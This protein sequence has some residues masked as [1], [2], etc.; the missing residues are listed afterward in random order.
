MTIL[1]ERI[2]DA[3]GAVFEPFQIKR[4]AKAEAEAA[5]IKAAG[6]IEVSDLQRRAVRRLVHQE[7]RRQR[8]IEQ[9]TS[10]ALPDVA[11]DASPERIESDWLDHFFD[12]SRRVSD[13]EMQTIWGRL[14]AGEAN[15][16]GAFSRRTIELVSTLD[17]NDVRLFTSLCGFAWSIGNIAPLIYDTQADIYNKAGIRFDSLTH[18]DS[19]GLLR[20]EALSGF[21]RQRLPKTLTVLY[22]GRPVHIEYPGDSDN[23]LDIGC[24]VLT[25]AGQELAPIAGSQP[26]DGFVDY[27][28][29]H[30]ERKGYKAYLTA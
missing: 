9:V 15:K 1:I 25:A 20:V 4:V 21:S 27:V 17:K 24:V 7:A 8:N 30:W 16:P 23:K 14:L 26:V 13:P 11:S 10:L 12:R 6:E 28:L 3:V 5:I 22:Y 29:G 19:I 2:S 18:L